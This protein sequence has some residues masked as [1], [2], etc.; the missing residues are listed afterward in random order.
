MGRTISREGIV[1]SQKQIKGVVDFPQPLVNTQLRSFLGFANY[2][3]DH[4]PNYSNTTAPLTRMINYSAKK[5]SKICWTPQGVTAFNEI[6]R[7]ISI[8]PM[9]Y[10]IDDHAPVFLMTDASDYG[11][12]GYLYQ[13]CNGVKQLIALVSK[14]LT[15]SQLR[16]SVIQKEAYGIY[17]SC[18]KL[19]TLLRD[20]KFTILTDH[21][22][23]MYMTHASNAMVIRWWMALQELD[24]DIVHIQGVKNIIADTLSRLC[25]NNKEQQFRFVAAL[26]EQQPMTAEHYDVIAVCHNT[27][28]GHGGVERTLRKLTQLNQK[29]EYMRSDV[30]EFI[31]KCPCCQKMSQV[32]PAIHALN[33]T[34][35]TYSPMECLNIDFIGPFPDRGYLLVII[36]TFTRWVEIYPT[37]DASA[38]SA[39]ESL[40]KHFGR[41]GAPSVIR[42]D[43]GPHFA[44]KV[45]QEFLQAVGTKHNLTLVY[46]SQEN[47]IVERCNKEINRHIRAFTFERATTE[48]YQSIIPFVQRIL[49][50]SVNDTM[51]TSPAQLLFGNAISLDR[52]ILL[53]PEELLLPLQSLTRSTSRM[54]HDQEVLLSTASELLRK[55]DE[56]H[57]DDQSTNLTVFATDSYVLAAPR[58]QPETRMH[59]QWSGPYKVLSHDG[60][61][62]TLLD[63]VTTRTKKYHVS[64]LKQFVFDTMN[65]DPTDIARRDHLEFLVEKILE[66]NGDCSK[67]SSLQF[68]VKWLGYDETYNSWEPWSALRDTEQLHHFLMQVN[69]QHLI[70]KKLKTTTCYKLFI[71]IH[72]DFSFNMYIYIYNF[73]FSPFI[74]SEGFCLRSFS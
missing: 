67:V 5:Q 25:E 68:K 2:F 39:C 54:L 26:Y 4:V 63:L 20:R 13:E 53:P 56:A 48:G 51:K 69:L 46:S 36:C 58:S 47:A 35:S 3:R 19:D 41:Y 14:A 55:A 61:E 21:K 6:K 31:R 34:T 74:T 42:S 23:L 62:Y 10:F 60:N 45:I 17:Y 15:V 8:S 12:G 43:N 29:W 71:S 37:P 27:M 40:L 33:Y 1:I 11:I 22:N 66:F 44:N 73:F 30:R 70:P 28:V 38:K 65:T 52:G 18:N 7:L 59:T 57:K 24:F 49:N 32:K 9:L 72:E 16:W 50:A 64:K